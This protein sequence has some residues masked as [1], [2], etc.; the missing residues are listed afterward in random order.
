MINYFSINNLY[1]LYSYRIDFNVNE[2]DTD[3]YIKFITGPNG[4]GKTTV[5]NII[6]A[7]LTNK[8]SKL[9]SISFDS[10]EI[11]IDNAVLKIKQSEIS[12]SKLSEDF[13]F[14]TISK[15]L[16]CSF[17]PTKDSSSVS[18]FI[19]DEV[20][21]PLIEL[22]TNEK[23]KAKL[24]GNK[25]EFDLFI[26]SRLGYFISDKRVI[27]S[28]SSPLNDGTYTSSLKEFANDLKLLISISKV[29]LPMLAF[30]LDGKVDENSA[31]KDEIKAYNVF[32]ALRT[33]DLIDM[34]SIISVSND[35]SFIDIYRNN[36]MIIDEC[37]GGV[38]N[39]LKK[40]QLFDNIISEANLANKDI[41]FS[42]KYGFR[43]KMRDKNNTI[44][45][46]NDL[47]SGEKHI[48]TQFY[49][50]LFT[51]V[52]DKMVVLIDEPEISFHMMWLTNY[53][54]NIRKIVDLRK[55]QFIIA[56]HSPDI[57]N[58]KWSLTYDL[59]EGNE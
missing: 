19:L 12:E 41:Q 52:T 7:I 16:E 2:A 38:K 59:Y 30:N 54:N 42:S 50:M 31:T 9:F 21:E 32:N 45:T 4:Y 49:H 37:F 1:N 29:K 35:V 34:S 14:E 18:E 8:L 28:M 56:T 15:R 43:F 33:Y 6:D 53:L 36:K 23:K 47:S 40:I 39:I 17:S 51:A 26:D 22:L 46:F 3:S 55:T 10:L 25:N 27:D 20:Y 11:G 58:S 13:D 24:S 5:L 44:L 48:V 57:F